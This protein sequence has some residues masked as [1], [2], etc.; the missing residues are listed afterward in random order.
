MR[1]AVWLGS[2]QELLDR[3]DV[4]APPPAV[5]PDDGGD[6]SEHLRAD[7]L[8]IL[9]QVDQE[10]LAGTKFDQLRQNADHLHERRLLSADHRQA[11]TAVE[12]GV[13][14]QRQA[15]RLS[16]RS[17]GAQSSVDAQVAAAIER[18]VRGSHRCLER[19]GLDRE[20]LAE[21]V[22]EFAFEV[23]VVGGYLVCHFASMLGDGLVL[24]ELTVGQ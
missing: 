15:C 21:V 12:E 10:R 24:A 4:H 3:S 1:L 17:H 13:V 16:D 7:Q 14:D 11:A 19:P 2:H 23:L 20:F 18:Q 9:V 6:R 22:G 8:A 5:A